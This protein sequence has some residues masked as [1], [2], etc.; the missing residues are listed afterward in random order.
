M[1]KNLVSGSLLCR[2][3][4]KLVFESN[5]LVVS[6]FGQFIGKVYD[7][8]GMFRLFLSDFCNSVVNQVNC[9][10]NDDEVN[11]WHSRLCHVNF[12][13]IARLSTLF[14]I[15]KLP[16]VKGSKCQACVQA[17]QPRKPHFSIEER[18]N[19]IRAHTF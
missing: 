2:D 18:F 1:K 3:G 10:S 15:P 13:S 17:K 9:L 8:G 5:K 7:S 4:F 16:I 12:G 19:T 11:V 6:R 14:L